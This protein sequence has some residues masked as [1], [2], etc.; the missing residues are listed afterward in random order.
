MK[1]G[2]VSPRSAILARKRGAGPQRRYRRR[3]RAT[4]CAQKKEMLDDARA[5]AGRAAGDED[6]TAMQVGYFAK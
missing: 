4:P 6:D 5:Y 1:S 2:R 3:R